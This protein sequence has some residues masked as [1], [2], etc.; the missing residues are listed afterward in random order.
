MHYKYVTIYY[1]QAVKAR[2]FAQRQLTIGKRLG[3]EHLKCRARIFIGISTRLHITEY[4]W[5]TLANVCI[6]VN[7]FFHLP[8]NLGYYLIFQK[9]YDEAEQLLQ[10]QLEKAAKE[11]D[12]E[13]KNF[14]I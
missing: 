10:R 8:K 1:L 12:K 3:N 4:K 9:Q 5:K 6:V 7:L 14:L 2:D 13:V 11:H